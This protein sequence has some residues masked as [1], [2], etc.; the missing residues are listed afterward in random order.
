MPANLTTDRSKA[1][2]QRAAVTAQL[3][4]VAEKQAKAVAKR[5]GTGPLTVA[6]AE[7]DARVLAVL[8]K[9]VK[10]L[11]E[12]DAAARD[13]DD[14]DAAPDDVDHLRTALDD[15]LRRLAAERGAEAV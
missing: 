8:A 11:A 9:T 14:Q 15:R 5:L 1:D 10:E 3:W 4:S 7:R 13:E 2:K 6:D 12:L